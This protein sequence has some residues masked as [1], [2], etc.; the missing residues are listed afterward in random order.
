M[1]AETALDDHE[2]KGEPKKEM[3]FGMYS[4]N[5]TLPNISPSQE[6]YV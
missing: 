2:I 1:E 4:V 6:I 5:H 3:N